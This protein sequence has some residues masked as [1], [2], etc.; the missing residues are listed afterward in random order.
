MTEDL[1]GLFELPVNAELEQW[2]T[3]F[4]DLAVTVGSTSDQV[5]IYR[6]TLAGATEADLIA[7][8]AAQ[9]LRRTYEEKREELRELEQQERQTEQ[10]TRRFADTLSGSFNSALESAIFAGKGFGEVVRSLGEDLARLIIRITIF[11]PLAESLGSYIFSRFW[12][13]WRWRRVPSNHHRRRDRSAVRH[14]WRGWR[15][16][17]RPR[18]RRKLSAGRGIRGSGNRGP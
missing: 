7:A 16:P 5:D 17:E 12:R 8:R 14:R 18:V 4:R 9:E 6:F 3:R 1:Q 13:G 15:D 2:R 11:R 10:E